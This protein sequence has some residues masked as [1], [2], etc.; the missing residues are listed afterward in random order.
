MVV[1]AQQAAAALGN[2]LDFTAVTGRADSEAAFASMSSSGVE[3]LF[4][5]PS[6]MLFLQR[7]RLV[8]LA[9]TRHGS[10][11]Q[12]SA[13]LERRYFQ[14]IT[15]LLRRADGRRPSSVL[16]LGRQSVVDLQ[17][18]RAVGPG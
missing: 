1:K 10:T 3:A 12:I 14:P 16:C 9:L 11:E 4:E 7:Q 2:T 8:D 18:Q 15:A 13:L 17:T 5:F 6:Q